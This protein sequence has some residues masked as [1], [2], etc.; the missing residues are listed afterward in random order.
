MYQLHCLPTNANA[1]RHMLYEQLISL[2][3]GGVV[4]DRS[5]HGDVFLGR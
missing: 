1:P 4:S 3:H 5:S 2:L